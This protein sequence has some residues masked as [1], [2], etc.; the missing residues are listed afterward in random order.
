MRQSKSLDPNDVFVDNELAYLNFRKANNAP[1]DIG[2]QDLVDA[3]METLASVA[4]KRPDQ[5]AHTA[6]IAGSQGLRWVQNS[7]M[8]Q[9]KKKEFLEALLRDVQHAMPDDVENM[10][11]HLADE[12]KR[13]ILMMA[14]PQKEAGD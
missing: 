13:A 10:L 5:R 14:V 7:D 9:K 12:L 4:L 2:S 11:S 1:T 3:A 8:T 6:H